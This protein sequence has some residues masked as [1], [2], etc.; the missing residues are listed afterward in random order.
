MVIRFCEYGC[1]DHPVAII[2]SSVPNVATAGTAEIPCA[3]GLP[4]AVRRQFVHVR[5]GVELRRDSSWERSVEDTWSAMSAPADAA[6]TNVDLERKTL[7]RDSESVVDAFAMTGC[8]Q[9][10]RGHF[11]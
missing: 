3:C 4:V 1:G 2:V 8:C 7:C 9:D 10:G 6:M 5:W 11:G